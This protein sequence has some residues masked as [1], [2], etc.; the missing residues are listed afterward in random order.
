MSAPATV[1]KQLCQDLAVAFTLH[2]VITQHSC[3]FKLF[4]SFQ[5]GGCSNQEEQH[6]GREHKD[7]RLCVDVGSL[8]KSPDSKHAANPQLP[9]R[10]TSSAEQTENYFG[11]FMVNEEMFLGE[12]GNREENSSEEMKEKK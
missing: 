7:H 9:P 2:V 3:I 1:Q 4:L 12:G 5:P 6:H 8:F 10:F 11:Y